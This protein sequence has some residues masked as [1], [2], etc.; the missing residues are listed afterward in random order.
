MI[1]FT[2]LTQME[3]EKFVAL[4]RLVGETNDVQG[5]RPLQT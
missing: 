3:A 2:I 4:M 1:Q 5:T